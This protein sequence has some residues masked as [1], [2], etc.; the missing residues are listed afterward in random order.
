MNERL[1]SGKPHEEDYSL[2][3]NL[4]PRHLSDYVGQHRVKSNLEIAIAAARQRGEPLDH[5]L[6]YGPPGLGKT[7][8]ANIVATEMGVRI[9]TT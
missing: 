5:I 4:R 8:L 1:V 2:D 9:K 6:V 3:T 7:T